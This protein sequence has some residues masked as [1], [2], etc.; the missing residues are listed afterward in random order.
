MT[1][2]LLAI[3]VAMTPA[4]APSVSSVPPSPDA[5]LARSMLY[6]LASS[7]VEEDPGIKI[8]LE[9]VHKSFKRVASAL[10][11]L[12]IP[13]LFDSGTGLSRQ[14]DTG[15]SLLAPYD[16]R[17]ENPRYAILLSQRKA[18]LQLQLLASTLPVGVRRRLDRV[19]PT[20]SGDI[21]RFNLAK[22]AT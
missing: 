5:L 15:I 10:R 3:L 11:D 6:L 8:P 4:R 9:D 7:A 19:L 1:Y 22:A 21:R 2:V 18:K 16:L 12:Q 13:I 17:I 20:F 14:I